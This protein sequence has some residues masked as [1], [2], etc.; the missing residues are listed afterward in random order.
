MRPAERHRRSRRRGRC[1]AIRTLSSAAPALSVPPD[2]LTSL[3][4]SI[5]LLVEFATKVIVCVVQPMLNAL[6]PVVSNVKL[7]VT[8]LIVTARGLTTGPA[9]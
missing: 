8:P 7:L 1:S 5:V 9:P 2:A 6:R 3:T 4:K